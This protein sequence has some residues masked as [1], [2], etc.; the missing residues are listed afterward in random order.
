MDGIK[1]FVLSL[2]SSLSLILTDLLIVLRRTKSIT[3]LDRKLEAISPGCNVAFSMT[4]RLI[5]VEAHAYFNYS[6]RATFLT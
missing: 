3:L 5:R 2:R 1:M 4:K 6:S